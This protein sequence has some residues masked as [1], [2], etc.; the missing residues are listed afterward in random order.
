MLN[1]TPASAQTCQSKKVKTANE[2]VGHS[3]HAAP[4]NTSYQLLAGYKRQQAPLN[5]EWALQDGGSA[6][7]NNSTRA[8][9]VHGKWQLTAPK[10]G[11]NSPTHQG[12]HKTVNAQNRFET[13]PQPLHT[14][15]HASTHHG[16]SAHC[17]SLTRTQIAGELPHAHVSWLVDK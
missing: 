1:H 14:N 3:H 4:H 11:T 15:K 8:S 13:A 12:L 10:G 17:T 6:L 5:S 7:Y 2:W 16:A 9:D